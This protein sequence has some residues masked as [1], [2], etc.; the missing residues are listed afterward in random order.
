MRK[1]IAIIL[2]SVTTATLGQIGGNHAY[3]F[4][5][6]PAHAR[7]AALG[8]VNVSLADKDVNFFHNNPALAGDTL[9]GI[10]SVGYQFY[11]GD[12]GNALFTYAHNFPGWGQLIAGLQHTNYGTIQGY[13]ESGE[14]TQAYSSGE[15][16][17]LIGRTHQIGHIRIGATA[18]AV[19]SSIA[20][21]RASALMVDLGGVFQHP[22]RDLAVGLTLK[23]MGI[24]LNDYSQS[25]SGKV[26]FDVQAGVSLKP[27]HMPVRFSLT[28]YNL[29]KSGLLAGGN[30]AP[31]E[32]V[33]AIKRIFSH[34][35]AGA[36]ILLH[37]NVTAMLGYNYLLHQALKS[38]TG[39]AAAGFSY[40]F[41]L[42]VKPVEFIFGR[43][44]YTVG[45]A[46]Y[47]FTLST[48]T[49]QF[50]KRRKL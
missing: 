12:V 44:A 23:N 50:L 19:F 43:S 36:E 39:N 49:N 42:F 34:I 3:D 45:N 20:G 21:Y 27:E 17:I 7:L 15:T 28:G 18:K 48:N 24:V 29:G 14:Q 41:S 32:N 2:C 30:L 16:A 38:E 5:H 1:I 40:G 37:K 47:S 10:A 13:D 26:P 4:L 31:S 46:G 25:S 11:V 9:N 8:G 22:D 35:S 6:L 33:S